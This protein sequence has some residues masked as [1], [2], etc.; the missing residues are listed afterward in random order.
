MDA[1]PCPVCG[2]HAPASECPHCGLRSAEASL[3]GRPPGRITSAW[4][5]LRAVPIGFS[6]LV[7]TPGIK[8]FLIPPLVLTV[9][10]FGLIANWLWGRVHALF[11]AIAL[12]DPAALESYPAWIRWLAATKLLVWLVAMGQWIFF[13]V[14]FA[15]VAVWAFSIVY[16]AIAGPF[17]DEIHGRVEERWFGA[18]PRKAIE[19]PT[20]LSSRECARHCYI[21]LVPSLAL[22]A[23]A[24]LA[25]GAAA[26]WALA[27]A[28]L[29]WV[30]LGLVRPQ[31]GRWLWW[32]V[33]IES[34]ALWVS[35]QAAALAGLVLLCFLW[36]KLVPWVGP[37]LFYALAGFTV[38]LSLLD[39][40]FSR[41]QWK[42]SRRLTFLRLHWPALVAF[43]TVA[44]LVYLIPVFGQLVMVP[45]ASLGGL[46]L[47]CRLDK[48][49]LRPA[50]VRMPIAVEAAAEPRTA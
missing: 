1:I 34:R 24:W 27:L 22:L 42:L 28:P 40:P 10:A 12:G 9:L 38:A 18:D 31:W 2:Y 30:G 7:R 44:S 32:I 3:R 8:R 23:F 20:T 13:L 11:D 19:R 48:N 25:S 33:K 46:W 45:A 16:E 15:L 21:A 6:I 14:A 36:L 29:P 41:R 43:G 49:G 17:L 35:V 26:G 37:L 39:I 4:A 50:E 5:G 47:L